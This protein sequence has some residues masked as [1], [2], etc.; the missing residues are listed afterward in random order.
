MMEEV[1]NTSWNSL[2]IEENEKRGGGGFIEVDG[3]H[4]AVQSISPKFV[5]KILAVFA[6]SVARKPHT[7]QCRAA[8]QHKSSTV[9][10]TPAH[11]L[12]Q[13]KA[14][15]IILTK[16]SGNFLRDVV[17]NRKSSPTAS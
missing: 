1:E 14:L 3:Y 16:A 15:R 4:K 7:F 8:A 10:N 17:A 6:A 9:M 2:G 12:D 13:W 5:K 11:M